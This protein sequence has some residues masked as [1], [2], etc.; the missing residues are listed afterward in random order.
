M[1]FVS[2]AFII[3]VFASVI[4]VNMHNL[5]DNQYAKWNIFSFTDSQKS[6][7]ASEKLYNRQS[8]KEQNLQVPTEFY[9]AYNILLLAQLLE[10][11]NGSG[12]DE[13]VYLTGVIVLKRL[14]SDDFPNTLKEVVYQKGQY[15]TAPK[16]AKIKPS[17]RC[18]EIAEELLIYGVEQY[19][20][21]LIYQS[22]F[23]QGSK[24]YKVIND[25]Y[26]CLK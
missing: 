2:T 9:T 5:T 10:A 14:Q 4:N 6:V 24:I 19:P 15:S 17:D 13:M 18:M 8:V 7:R 3:W 1:Y 26:F 21:N 11:E 16:L 12:T 23:P 22:M 25:E 20:D